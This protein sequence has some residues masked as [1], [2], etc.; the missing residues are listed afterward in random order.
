MF[1]LSG[2]T[3]D[4]CSWH[5]EI[6]Q[7]LFSTVNVL[8]HFQLCQ[9]WGISWF[10][11]DVGVWLQIWAAL[12]AIFLEFLCWNG[13]SLTLGCTEALWIIQSFGKLP[14]GSF[15]SATDLHHHNIDVSKQQLKK[16]EEVKCIINCTETH[17]HGINR[18][19]T[20]N[21]NHKSISHHSDSYDHLLKASGYVIADE[22]TLPNC[23]DKVVW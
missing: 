4:F 8:Q 20:A 9:F 13:F 19:R 18:R 10:W 5:K 2:V 6:Q 1:P 23:T 3:A 21:R 16:N 22:N 12:T 7:L 11:T 15:S 17:Q 14:V